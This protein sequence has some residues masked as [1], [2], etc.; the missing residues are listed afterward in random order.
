MTWKGVAFK[1]IDIGIKSAWPIP[2]N[3]S[4][5]H[6]LVCHLHRLETGN[7]LAMFDDCGRTGL[8]INS[9]DGTIIADEELAEEVKPAPGPRLV[10]W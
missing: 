7:L 10:D 4:T 6:R 3:I 8:W 2:A 5:G 1:K 9:S